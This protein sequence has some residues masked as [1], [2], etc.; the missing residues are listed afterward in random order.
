[1][2]PPKMATPFTSKVPDFI[3]L[4]EHIPSLSPQFLN[5]RKPKITCKLPLPWDL[6]ACP[7]NSLALLW[8]VR[9]ASWSLAA[10]GLPATRTQQQFSIPAEEQWGFALSCAVLTTVH[11]DGNRCRKSDSTERLWLWRGQG[12]RMEGSLTLASLGPA[13]ECSFGVS[14]RLNLIYL[15]SF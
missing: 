6:I 7:R 8:R 5:E 9:E 3:R 1:M 11:R 15:W 2:Y 4:P 14:R 12:S 13:L 10:Y